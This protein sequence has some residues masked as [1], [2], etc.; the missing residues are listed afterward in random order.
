MTEA[1]LLQWLSQWFVNDGWAIEIEQNRT[2]ALHSSGYGEGPITVDLND[3]ARELYA[4][5]NLDC[6]GGD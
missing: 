1:K 6:F 5:Q 2:I 4:R 3:L